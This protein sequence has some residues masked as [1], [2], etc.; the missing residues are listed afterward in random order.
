VFQ[1]WAY[2]RVERRGDVTVV[3]PTVADLVGLV[4]NSELRTELLRFVQGEK[5]E[6]VVVDF[7]NIQR[8]LTDW[9]STL[10]SLKKRLVVTGG[11]VKLCSMQPMHREI[12]RVCNLDGTA[13]PILENVDEAVQSFS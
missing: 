9:I 3:T 4:I 5:P 12:F 10:L 6:K 13:F 7:H 1:E 2:F 11:E 8:F